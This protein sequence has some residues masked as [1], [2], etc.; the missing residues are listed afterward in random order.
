MPGC[1]G[2]GGGGEGEAVTY[3]LSITTTPDL[4][5]FQAGETVTI[6]ATVTGS[7]GL[8]ASGYAVTFTVFRN[9]SGGTLT[10]AGTGTTDSDGRA[11]ATY[12]LGS[13]D[14]SEAVADTIEVSIP[15]SS[16]TITINRAAQTYS[17]VVSSNETSL[18]A[19]EVATLTAT[20]T[21]N[22]GPVSGQAISFVISTN[23]SSGSIA[24]SGTGTTDVNGQATAN[25]TAGNANPTSQLQDTITVGALNATQS[26]TITRVIG[27][28]ENAATLDLAASPTSI[29]TD[30]SNISTITVN[31]LTSGNAILSGVSVNLSTDT[32]IL[33][34]PTVTTPGNVTLTCG[35]NKSN[36]TATITATSGAATA[37]IPVSIVGSTV[38]LAAGAS[39]ISTTGSTALT[40]TVKDAG[41]NVVSGTDV[42][43]TQSG[44]GTVTFGAASGTT[45]SSGVFSTTVTGNTNGTVTITATALGATA[46][47]VI[48]VTDEATVFYIDQQRLCPGAY[49]GSCAGVANSNPTAMQL[50]QKLEIRVN[51]PGT[52]DNVVF[53]TTAGTFTDAS[54][55]ANT[56]GVITVAVDGSDKATAYL[57]TTTAGI[58]TI[59][60][61]DWA[62]PA[63]NDSLT[64]AMTSA[65][66][67]AIELQA[68]PIIVP[69]SVG[70]TTGS[71]TLI[72]MVRDANGYPVGNAPVLFSIVNPTGGGETISPV[73]VMSA[74]T[75]AGG[76]NLGEARSSFTSGSLPSAAGGIQVSASIVGTPAI[77]DYATIVI[78]GVA[79]SVAFGQATSLGVDD[80]A[81]NYTLQMSVLVADS[82]GNPAPEGTVVNLSLWPIAWST[83]T[84]CSY[85]PDG[86]RWD[87]SDPPICIPGN[88][89]TFWNEDINENLILDAGE[90]GRRLFY[91]SSI[92][93][94]PGTSDGYI[95]AVNSAAGTVPA[96][97]TTDANGVAGFK[98]T[99]A[100][101]SSIWTVVRVR[102][103]TIVQGTET[104]GEVNFRLAPLASDVT[105]TCKIT[106]SPYNF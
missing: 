76:L 65:I 88:F 92:D 26:V 67:A 50:G 27:A 71:S 77:I 38:T 79:G 11:Q 80:T 83:G 104:V 105:P 94:G 37:Q 45:N 103:S 23:N 81:A 100:K 70:T 74:A 97:V 44:T 17:L 46:S 48:T 90:D 69:K 87:D 22:N 21:D 56:G 78:G 73:V 49:P 106:G 43:L 10:I 35:G 16:Q 96:T 14:S 42:T 64:V 59:N 82:N 30:N 101:T 3:T 15:G 61:Y 2:G 18:A 47:V 52:I 29:K 19:G 34:S 95:T 53:A 7:D 28:S 85:D 32:G 91:D 4:D 84:G 62:N 102:A 40:V 1:G 13:N 24:I 89:G 72:A 54:N 39:S 41:S 57:T 20:L 60:I 6:I 55:P 63:T 9:N 8:A 58:A 75:T 68:S 33:S 98:L 66:P 5:N 51:A 36:R 31:A 25:Y 93:G 86:C 99:Y 12:T